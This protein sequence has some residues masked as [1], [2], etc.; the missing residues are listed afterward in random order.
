MTRVLIIDDEPLL[1][2]MLKQMLEIEGYETYTA[3]NGKEGL[4]VFNQR[5]PDIVVTDIIMPEKEGL[6][7]IQIL[8]GQKPSLK[9]LAISGGSFHINVSDV[10]KMAKALGANQTLSKPIRRKEFIDAVN[11]LAK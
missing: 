11:K 10:L 1:S 3:G 4:S 7:L 2:D 5:D 6:E 8:K 9:I